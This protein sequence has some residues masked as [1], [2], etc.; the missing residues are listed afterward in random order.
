MLLSARNARPSWNATIVSEYV[1]VHDRLYQAAGL[2]SL[3]SRAFNDKDFPV[4][5]AACLVMA[6]VVVTINRLVWK[7]LQAVANDRCR[8]IA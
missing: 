4:L 8:F 7:R 5:A 2:G 3:I 1:T 6:A